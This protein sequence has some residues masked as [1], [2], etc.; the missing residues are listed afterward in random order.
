MKVLQRNPYLVGSICAYIANYNRIP[1][2]LAADIVAA[3]KEPEL[4]HA[5]NGS[6]LRASLGKL[7]TQASAEVGQFAANRLLRPPRNVIQLQ[8]G[9]KEALVACALNANALTFAE[10]EKIVL[11]EKD[12]WVRKSCLRQLDESRYGRAS[13]AAFVNKCLRVNEGEVARVASSLMLRNSVALSKPYGDVETTAK[14]A[15]KVAGIIKI[16]GSRQPK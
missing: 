3:V 16:V 5:V 6:L 14:Q 7:N 8:P 2:R 11:N 15:L 1:S 13:Y 10:Y 12:W 9:Y 4:Y